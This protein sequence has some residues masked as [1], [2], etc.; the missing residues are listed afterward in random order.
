MDRPIARRVN[1]EKAAQYVNLAKATLEKD[2]VT[3]RLGIPFAKLGRRV[4]YDL[5]DL[6]A[7]VDR[8]RRRHTSD[9]GTTP[10]GTNLS[11]SPQVYR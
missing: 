9:D 6:D 4:I 2:R 1:T 8:R 3:G 5:N 7:W 11:P 10:E